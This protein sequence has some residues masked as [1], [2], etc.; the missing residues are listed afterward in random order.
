[1]DI[2]ARDVDG[3][4]LAVAEYRVRMEAVGNDDHIAEVERAAVGRKDRGVIAVEVSLVAAVAGLDDL[5]VAV[6]RGFSVGE[7]RVI[8]VGAVL[9]RF[10]DGDIRLAQ[11]CRCGFCCRLCFNRSR[12]RGLGCRLCFDRAFGSQASARRQGQNQH[13]G[14]R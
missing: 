14:K 1:M 9:D 4:I 3:C 2:A 8:T 12:R 13:T 11:L 5:R 7:N 6:A 10:V